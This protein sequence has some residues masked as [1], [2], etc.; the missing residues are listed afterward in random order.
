MKALKC[1]KRV[2]KRPRLPPEKFNFKS[3][4]PNWSIEPEVMALKLYL[5]KSYAD[6]ERCIK[7]VNS[8]FRSARKDRLVYSARGGGKVDPNEKL[9]HLYYKIEFNLP[10][11]E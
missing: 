4:N 7:A 11:P 2:S 10:K 3:D 8:Y 9:E 6:E 1:P 5:E